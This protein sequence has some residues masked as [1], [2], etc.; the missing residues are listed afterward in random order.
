VRSSRRCDAVPPTPGQAS[1]KR[2]NFLFGGRLAGLIF[3]HGSRAFG[4]SEPHLS[5]LK[6][7]RWRP[8]G[9]HSNS[10]SPSQP[11]GFAVQKLLTA[12]QPCFTRIAN[13]YSHSEKWHDLSS[14]RHAD[15]G[16]GIPCPSGVH[17]LRTRA[18]IGAGGLSDRARQ[19]DCVPPCS[20]PG[21]ARLRRA[22]LREETV[23]TDPQAA[24]T[25]V[26]RNRAESRM[27]LFPSGD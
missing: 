21:N 16:S 8:R 17:G 1:L 18:H 26:P 5:P 13:N 4:F 10:P 7:R 23:S 22:N 2:Q 11:P 14:R 24:R 27:V 3:L 25:G 20:D 15:F 6:S 19:R 9:P 12:Q